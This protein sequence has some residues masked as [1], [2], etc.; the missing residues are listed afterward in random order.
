MFHE[1][2]DQIENPGLSRHIGN[3]LDDPGQTQVQFNARDYVV[4]PVYRDD[5]W[6]RD[7]EEEARR[8][9]QEQIEFE[10]NDLHRTEDGRD[11][12]SEDRPPKPDQDSRPEDVSIGTSRSVGGLTLM[13]LPEYDHDAR[14]E[15]PDWVTVKEYEPSPGDPCSGSGSESTALVARTE[16]DPGCG[17][18]PDAP[19][20][21]AGRGEKLDI[22][23][24]IEA[25]IDLKSGSTPDYRVY[26]RISPPG[27]RSPFISC[28]ICRNRQQTGSGRKPSCRSNRT[29]RPFW[30]RRWSSW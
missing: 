1:H 12:R 6:K 11:P 7:F 15:R 17:G 20:E 2:M 27:A 18:W 28:W 26:E 21:T 3:L 23:A 16:D 4:Q 30:Q 9:P 5:N 22:D 10:T 8:P 14:I 24:S 13:K 25:S 29:R 19:P